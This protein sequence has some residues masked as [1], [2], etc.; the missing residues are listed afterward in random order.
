MKKCPECAEQV[1]A[2][3]VMCPYCQSELEPETVALSEELED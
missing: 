2:G 1:P 3:D